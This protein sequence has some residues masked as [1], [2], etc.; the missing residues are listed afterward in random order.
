MTDPRQMMVDPKVRYQV[1]SAMVAALLPI[2]DGICT[3]DTT[4]DMS[5]VMLS[6]A[7]ELVPR[8]KRPCAGDARVLG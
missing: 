2:L 4:P 8:S 3:S 6:T 5:D 7:T 1:E